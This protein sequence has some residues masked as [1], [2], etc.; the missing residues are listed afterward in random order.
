MLLTGV[1]PVSW[2]C[3]I[4]QCVAPRDSETYLAQRTRELADCDM[5]ARLLMLEQEHFLFESTQW[6]PRDLGGFKNF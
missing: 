5:H 4:L 2:T 3:G 1:P 6:D